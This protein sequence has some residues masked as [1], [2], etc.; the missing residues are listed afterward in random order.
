MRIFQGSIGICRISVSEV[1][2]KLVGHKGKVRVLDWKQDRGG[3]LVRSMCPIVHRGSCE[4]PVDFQLTISCPVNTFQ[5]LQ[6]VSENQ[7][8]ISWDCRKASCTKIC[9]EK[10]E[11]R[12]YVD[13]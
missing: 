8:R 12:R 11:L 6:G 7:W 9:A 3:I 13:V 2:K 10:T 1:V 5:H 4:E